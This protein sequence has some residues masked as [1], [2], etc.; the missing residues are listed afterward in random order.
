MADSATGDNVTEEVISPYLNLSAPL[1]IQNHLPLPSYL[2]YIPILGLHGESTFTYISPN[3]PTMAHNLNLGSDKIRSENSLRIANYWL[4]VATDH[5]DMAKRATDLANEAFTEASTTVPI[6]EADPTPTYN[7]GPPR[8]ARLVATYE[9]YSEYSGP[10]ES[11]KTL[12]FSAEAVAAINRLTCA[13]S[14]A[15]SS[16]EQVTPSLLSGSTSS[17][18]SVV[19]GPGYQVTL[20]FRPRH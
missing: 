8:E 1:H 7:A 9:G 5:I 10:W 12:V 16:A 20:P 3:I 18:N 15:R 11:S 4:E 2:Y 14:T 6:P 19:P 17:V 13:P